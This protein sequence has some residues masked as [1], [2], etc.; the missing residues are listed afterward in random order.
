[1]RRGKLNAEDTQ[2]LMNA[3]AGWAGGIRGDKTRAVKILPSVLTALKGL[4]RHL[5]YLH[6]S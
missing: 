3:I 2:E 6:Y 5:L 1:M 4:W